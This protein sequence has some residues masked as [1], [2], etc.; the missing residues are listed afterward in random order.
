MSSFFA[1]LCALSG[2]F[3]LGFS[4]PAFAME[5][6][7]PTLDVSVK[8]GESAESVF[9]LRNTEPVPETYLFTIQG[10]TARDEDGRQTF[11]PVSEAAGLPKWIYLNRATVTLKPGESA[12]VALQVRPPKDAMPGAYQ[13]VVFATHMDG[14]RADGVLLGSR[15]GVLVFATVEGVLRHDVRIG[16]MQYVG[17]KVIDHLPALFTATIRNEGTAH[18]VPQ[19]HVAIENMLG[20]LV[21][22]IDLQTRETPLRVLPGS[23]RRFEMAWGDERDCR[24]G[25]F[26]ALRCEWSPFAVGMYRARLVLDGVT[27]AAPSEEVRF[28][29]VPWRVLGS[30]LLVVG[31]LMAGWRLRKT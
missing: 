26:A 10:F 8:P 7:P 28:F 30:I 13:A 27:N 5:M 29:V 6:K 12:P 9:V 18:E 23:A 25:F 1:R 22:T 11:L 17:P 4:V 3:F 31:L 20:Q 15:V 24:G 14:Q 16:S 2:I 21:T 19:G